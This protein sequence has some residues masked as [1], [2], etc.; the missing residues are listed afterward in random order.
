[1]F[2]AGDHVIVSFDVPTSGSSVEFRA[3]V[4]NPRTE[5]DLVE[6]KLQDGRPA[7]VTPSRVRPEGVVDLLARLA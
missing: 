3:T 4:V 5:R 6:L 2:K 1:M 7:Y